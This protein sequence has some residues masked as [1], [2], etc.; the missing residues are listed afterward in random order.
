MCFCGSKILNSEISK[1]KF[2]DRISQCS[3]W[4]NFYHCN[5]CGKSFDYRH[6]QTHKELFKKT[7]LAVEMLKGLKKLNN[8]L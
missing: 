3:R 7:L 4:I 1:Q 5:K 6:L 2:R 8:I